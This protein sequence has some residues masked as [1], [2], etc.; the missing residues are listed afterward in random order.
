M[1]VEMQRAS[2][3]R[4]VQNKEFQAT[5]ND[6]AATQ[7]ILGKAVA[8]L[9]KFYAAKAKALLQQP[10]VAMPAGFKSY[11]KQGGTGVVAMMKEI[12]ND[13]KE[14]QAEATRDE[15]DAQ[16]AYESFTANSNDG[17]NARSK[18]IVNKTESKALAA[19]ERTEVE[20]SIVQQVRDLEML[21][22]Y[23][24]QLHASCDFVMKN[25]EIRQEARGQEIEALSQAKSILSGA[26]GS[27]FGA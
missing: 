16:E 22:D 8:R 10:A 18:D 1:R 11:K 27:E 2:E 5:V 3:D 23:K 19:Q 6:Q 21:N 7:A 15:Q 4:Q 25:F 13:A 9:E 20:A 12:M 17:I 26:G 14:M 24:G